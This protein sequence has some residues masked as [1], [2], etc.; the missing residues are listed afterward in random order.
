MSVVTFPLQCSARGIISL[1]CKYLPASCRDCLG[2]KGTHHK[3]EHNGFASPRCIVF[4]YIYRIGI[5]VTFVS[6]TQEVIA[7]AVF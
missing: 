5:Q 7:C 1:P 6:D 3:I 2:S 4:L